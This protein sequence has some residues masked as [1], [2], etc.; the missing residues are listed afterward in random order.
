MTKQGKKLG[1]PAAVAIAATTASKAAG[2]A[3]P[4]VKQANK[5]TKGAVSWLLVGGGV[6]GLYLLYKMVSTF[7]KA[8]DVVGDA[9]GA[10]ST[11]IN[12]ANQIS[13]AAINDILSVLNPPIPEVTGK[14]SISPTVAANKAAAL[15]EAMEG[16]GTN[17]TRIKN[18]FTG[19]TIDDFSLIANAFGLHY[20]IDLSPFGSGIRKR[21][22]KQ[23]LVLELD[24]DELAE[25]NQLIPGLF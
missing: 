14:P 23:W 21:D 6:L 15:L 3:A 7:G 9:A 5:D 16:L 12:G 25:L 4:A 22:L 13:Q 8:S 10:A 17:F 1:N 2:K 11:V 18:V 24:D 19:M 20:Y